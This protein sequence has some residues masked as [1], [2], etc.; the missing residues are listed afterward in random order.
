MTSVL[1]PITRRAIVRATRLAWVW[2]GLS[3]AFAL[4]ARAQNSSARAPVTSSQG[5]LPVTGCAGQPISDIVVITQP[6]FTDRLPRRLEFVRRGVRA[7]HTNTHDEIVRRFLLLKV[8][9]PCNQIQRAESER[10]LRAQPYFVD[11]RLRVYDDEAGGVRLEVET[12][13]DVSLLFSPVIVAVS[14]FLRSLQLGEGNIAGRAQRGVLRW[15]DGRGYQ[16]MYGLEYTNYLFGAARN[17]LRVDIQRHEFGHFV[18]LQSVRPYYTDLQRAAWVSGFGLAREPAWFGRR[19]RN[20]R[21]VLMDREY[22]QLGG[23]VRFGSVGGLKLVGGTLTREVARTDTALLRATPSGFIADPSGS[24]LPMFRPQNVVRVNALLGLRSIRF[25]R[26]QGFDALAGAQDVRV[27]AQLGL[28]A[29]QS[30]PI[31]SAIDRDRFVAANVYVGAGSEK[32]FMAAQGIT[33]ARYDVHAKRWTNMVSSGR[34]AWYFRPAVRQTTVLQGEWAAGANME[35]PFHLSLADRLGGM[36]AHGRSTDLG[37]R[38]VVLR[39]EQRLVVPT[40][41]NLADVGLAG[42]AEAGRLWSAPSVPFSVTTPWRGVVGVSVL[43]ALPPRSRRLW[44]IDFAMP[45]GNDPAK[46]FQIR[47]SGVDRSRVFWQEPWDVQWSRERTAP[48]S[49]FNWP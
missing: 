16:D 20:P 46:R 24:A 29:G 22:A 38:R 49:L 39:G 7:L 37:A 47:F 35:K 12:R 4:P 17:E 3:A 1:L 18:D 42:F 36:L 14:P 15:R 31:A 26:V 28:V 10:I 30:V 8:G 2:G 5:R 25:L 40:R 23:V 43:A 9:E 6:P 19:E 44:R 27:G 32:W 33:E 41:L 13:D 21:A 34:T 48:T 11:A 45:V